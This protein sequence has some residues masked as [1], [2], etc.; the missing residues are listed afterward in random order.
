MPCSWVEVGGD[1]SLMV[2]SRPNG[3][4]MNCLVVP[5]GVDIFSDS[6]DRV[7]RNQTEYMKTYKILS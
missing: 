6:L 7:V 2:N 4:T 1:T 3:V 5:Y